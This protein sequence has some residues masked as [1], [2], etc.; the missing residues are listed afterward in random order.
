[1]YFNSSKLTNG[2]WCQIDFEVLLDRDP[3]NWWFVAVENS[4]SSLLEINK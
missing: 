4:H 3:A 2:K 1:M